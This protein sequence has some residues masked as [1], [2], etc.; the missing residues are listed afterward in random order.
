MTATSILNSFCVPTLHLAMNYDL[1][2]DPTAAWQ[3]VG[4]DSPPAHAAPA[5]E[6]PHEIARLLENSLFVQAHRLNCPDLF[7]WA[8]L[9]AVLR[10]KAGLADAGVFPGTPLKG[11]ELLLHVILD[12][13]P[14][15]QIFRHYLTTYSVKQ[16][17]TENDRTAQCFIQSALGDHFRPLI[18]YLNVL[19]TRLGDI[20]A[21][22]LPAQPSPF[23]EELPGKRVPRLSLVV[24]VLV[25]DS[26]N[27]DAPLSQEL[28]L[29]FHRL[30]KVL[31]DKIKNESQDLIV[32][33][34]SVYLR[35]GDAEK[36]LRLLGRDLVKDA[37]LMLALVHFAKLGADRALKL[38]D[39]TLAETLYNLAKNG[40]ARFNSPEAQAAIKYF[41]AQIKKT[42]KKR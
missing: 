39:L 8:R 19:N 12:I 6:K 5:P 21:A 30:L 20:S 25:D 27:T 34:T 42:L 29:E 32:G 28:V 37:E 26:I 4:F 14:P 22:V 2:D 16:P 18:Q 10:E 33:C 13:R 31:D 7:W 11:V 40:M 36:A 38:G 41:E 1:L 35:L 24:S 17:E 9:V 3:L 15:P 23:P